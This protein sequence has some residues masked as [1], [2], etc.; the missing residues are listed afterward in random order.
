M[1]ESR[2]KEISKKIGNRIFEL[3]K[4]NKYSREKFA[5]LC[6]VSSQHIYYMEKGDF[7]PGCI[8]LIDICNTFSISPSQ[9]LLDTLDINCNIFNE[10]IQKD[11]EKL[12]NKD[13]QFLQE[14]MASTIKLL[15]N[16]K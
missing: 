12:S 11:F 4:S 3:R 5:E 15:L 16:K 10:S 1:D 7:L 9:L 6:N 14:L 8:T 13:K 2:K